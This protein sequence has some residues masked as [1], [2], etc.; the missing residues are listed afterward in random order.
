MVNEDLGIGSPSSVDGSRN[1]GDPKHDVIVGNRRERELTA[2]ET[3]ELSAE[4]QRE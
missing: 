4:V 1:G 2:L 3:K